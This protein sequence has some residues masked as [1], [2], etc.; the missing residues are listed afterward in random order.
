[1]W[2]CSCTCTQPPETRPTGVDPAAAAAVEELLARAAALQPGS[3][4]PG[5]AR[6]ALLSEQVG[7]PN[8]DPSLLD[9]PFCRAR[10]SLPMPL[11]T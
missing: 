1:M 5:Q 3:P 4:E 10:T 7:D 8:P 6:A 11:S 9:L 2:V